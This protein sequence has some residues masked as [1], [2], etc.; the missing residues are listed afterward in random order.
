M[1]EETKK[2]ICYLI[3]SHFKMLKCFLEQWGLK[4]LKT[5]NGEVIIF[6]TDLHSRIEAKPGKLGNY[7]QIQN[8][9]SQLKCKIKRSEKHCMVRLAV[10]VIVQ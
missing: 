5:L 8:R 10:S 6:R 7:L 4:I 2:R 3:A 9:E 1:P